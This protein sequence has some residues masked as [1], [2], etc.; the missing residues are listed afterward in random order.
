M[1]KNGVQVLVYLIVTFLFVE[2]KQAEKV[3]PDANKTKVISI[4]GSSTAYGVGAS[5]IDSSWVR[6]L[7]S[8]TLLDQRKA[9]V[10]NLALSGFTTYHV[11]P[12]NSSSGNGITVDTSRN[13][14]KA[15]GY[16][17]D[18]VI[19]SLPSNDIAYNF[20]DAEILNNYSI[21]IRLIEEKNVP[22]II[23]STQPRN[24][25]ELAL[26]KR[27]KD[28]N[29]QLSTRFPSHI[30]DIYSDLA[31][32]TDLKIKAGLDSGDGIHVNNKGHAII[33]KAIYYN[34]IFRK[35]VGY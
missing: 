30:V 25:P 5:P 34:S 26:R 23:T 28:L 12:T 33:F 24:F 10:I 2:C 9:N 13:I 18:L 6:R 14:T 1:K 20:T 27:L 3:E 19:I 32:T 8:Q 17:P 31:D 16:Q 22:Y 4:V 15:L 21:L 7:Q 11:L 35:V 29:S